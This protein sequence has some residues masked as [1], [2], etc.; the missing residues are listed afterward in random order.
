MPA[1]ERE[2]VAHVATEVFAPLNAWPRTLLHALAAVTAAGCDVAGYAKTAGALHLLADDSRV[3]YAALAEAG[4]MPSQAEV[5]VVAVADRPGIA[6]EVFRRI[7]DGKI[8]VAF[9]YM[10]THDRIIIG[11]SDSAEAVRLLN[12]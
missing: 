7:A 6:R 4:F 10:A 11:A 3:A 12:G 9:S 2:P 8:N 1:L 5:A